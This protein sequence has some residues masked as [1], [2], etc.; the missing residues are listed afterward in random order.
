LE[1]SAPIVFHACVQ[2]EIPSPGLGQGLV[3]LFYLFEVIGVK[4]S[5]HFS[6][7]WCRVSHKAK[8]LLVSRK[9]PLQKV[10]RRSRQQLVEMKSDWLFGK[11]QSNYSAFSL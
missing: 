1:R 10:E 3:L 8:L 7:Y 4:R 5:R 11:P 2:A 9:W 6:C